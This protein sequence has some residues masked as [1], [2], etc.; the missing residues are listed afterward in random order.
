VTDETVNHET[1]D[2]LRNDPGAYRAYLQTRVDELVLQTGK[3]A[4]EKGNV[5]L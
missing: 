1:L 3:S 4:L 5:N 2:L